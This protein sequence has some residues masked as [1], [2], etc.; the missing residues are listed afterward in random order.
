MADK[1]ILRLLIVDDSPD[2]AEAAVQSIRKNGYM[3]KQAR[4]QDLASMQAALDKGPWDAVVSEYTLPHFGA[5]MAHDLLRN[6]NLDLPFIIVTHQIGDDDVLRIMRAGAHDVVLKSQLARLTPALERELKAAQDRAELAAATRT[7]KEMAQQHHAVIEGSRDA[8]CYSQDGMHVD[9]NKAYLDLFG[10]GQMSD[11]E[12]IPVMN[13]IDKSD[14]P[15]LKDFLRK[16]AGKTDTEAQ[17]FLGIKQDG[18]RFHVEIA[19]STIQLQGENG[20]QLAAADVSKRKAVESKLQFLNQ[21]DPLT[22]LYNRHYFLQEVTKAIEKTQR[23]EARGTIL[24]IDLEQLKTIND[25]LG[26]A[27]GDRLLIKIARLFRERLGESVLLARFGGDE[28][29][30]L[31]YNKSERELQEIAGT[32]H[33]ALKETSFT[34]DGKTYRCHCTLGVTAIDAQAENAQKVMLRA[35]HAAQHARPPEAAVPRKDTAAATPPPAA[36]RM[37]AVSVPS[38]TVMAQPAPASKPPAAPRPGAAASG[39]WPARIRAAL[40]KDAFQLTYQPIINLHGD[41][42]EMFEVL[43]RMAGEGEELITAGAFMPAAEASGLSKDIDRWVVRQAIVALGELHREG[44]GASFFVNLSP[45]A[46]ADPDLIPLVI[47]GVRAVGVRP[48]QLVFEV[49]EADLSAHP[50]EAKTLIW[51][52]TKI[53][54][55]FAIDN[56]GRDVESLNHVRDMPI[57]FLKLDG[58]LV[59]NLADPVTQAAVKAAVGVAKAIEKKVVA[60]S[61]EAADNL[62]ALWNLGVDYVQGHYFQQADGESG[63]EFVG[64]TTLSEVTAPNWATGGRR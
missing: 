63:Y 55:R 48:E 29:A 34:E 46:F 43:V 37:P 62:A 19:A 24:Y 49:D 44:R 8:I 22:G 53:G 15:R 51:A 58:A 33:N 50:A 54:C 10:Y 16:S 3:L 23:N 39:E 42:A 13:L 1:K 6:T 52:I 5:Q 2:D 64:E 45:S 7:V 57:Q 4:V 17:E 18:T 47:Q 27:T 21:H 36:E 56:F 61:V 14:H 38:A 11:L 12:G 31:L 9:A 30:A 35:Y 60:K 25:T 20:V 59:R 32:L 40:A 26:Y 28:F 41:A